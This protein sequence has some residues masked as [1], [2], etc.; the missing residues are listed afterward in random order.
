MGG[1]DGKSKHGRVLEGS[2]ARPGAVSIADESMAA[3]GRPGLSG[4]PVENP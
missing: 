3:V 1:T 2:R 4:L